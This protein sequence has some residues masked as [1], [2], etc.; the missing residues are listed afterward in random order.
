MRD[1][2]RYVGENRARGSNDREKYDVGNYEGLNRAR[3]M[4]RS[5]FSMI[6]EDRSAIAN[7]PQQVMYKE[8]PKARHYHDYGLDDTIKGIDRQLDKDN[9]KMESHLQPEK[10]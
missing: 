5:D 7:L 2:D 4:E 6:N 10:Y 8:W 3:D 9:A 1:K